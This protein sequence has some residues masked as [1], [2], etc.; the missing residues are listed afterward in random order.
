MSVL[1]RLRLIVAEDGRHGSLLKS[2]F[3][4]ARG[5]YADCRG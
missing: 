1:K 4:M 3:K 2:L 5:N